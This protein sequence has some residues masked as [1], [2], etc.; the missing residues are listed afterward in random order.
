[1]TLGLRTVGKIQLFDQLFYQTVIFLLRTNIPTSAKKFSTPLSNLTVM[2]DKY[3]AC[4]DFKYSSIL[5][6]KVD[7]ALHGR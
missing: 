6:N 2:S 1:M 3:N 7:L 4:V 5:L